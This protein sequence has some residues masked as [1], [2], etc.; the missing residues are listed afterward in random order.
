MYKLLDNLAVHGFNGSATNTK[1]DMKYIDAEFGYINDFK[2][3][4]VRMLNDLGNSEQE[5]ELNILRVTSELDEGNKV[6]ICCEAGQSRSN[7]IALGVLVKYFK[8]NF[9]DAW[10]LIRKEIPISNIDPCHIESLKKIFKVTS[11]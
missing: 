2:I 4:D 11:M 10:E 3:I 9:Y 8:M 6:V 5:Y 7:A 1:V